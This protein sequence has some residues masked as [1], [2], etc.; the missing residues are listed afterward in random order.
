FFEPPELNER[1]QQGLIKAFE[2]TFEL[3]WN[4]LRDLLR[5]RGNEN[6]LGSR[7][8]LREAFR[9]GLI[10]NGEAWML[11]IQDRNLTSHTYNRSTADAISLNIIG[12]YMNC[13]VDLRSTLLQLAKEA[14]T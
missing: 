14:E 9:L 8:T 12:T 5:S 11:M 10:A 7:D 3:A 4:S 2:Y 13:F 1:E 6:L